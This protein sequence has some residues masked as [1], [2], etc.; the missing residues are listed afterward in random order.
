MDERSQLISQILTSILESD[1]IDTAILT[2]SAIVKRVS[3][4]ESV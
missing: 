2:L 1:D 4:G 3:R